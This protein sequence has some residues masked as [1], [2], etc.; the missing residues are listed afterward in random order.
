MTMMGMTRMMMFTKWRRMMKIEPTMITM[1]MTMMMMMAMRMMTTMMM[2][3][4]MMMITIVI[5]M[6]CDANDDGN[7]NTVDCVRFLGLLC[8]REPEIALKTHLA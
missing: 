7:N 5:M 6:T 4:M 8:S 2:I 3:I 1:L